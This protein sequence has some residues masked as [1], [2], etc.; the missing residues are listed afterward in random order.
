[1]TGQTSTSSP[2][3]TT[4]GRPAHERATQRLLAQYRS[5][6]ADQPVRLAKKTSN[7]FRLRNRS[8]TG[9][10]VDDLTGVVEIDS[11][12]GLARV[13]GM[14]TYEHVVDALLPH[15]FMPMVVPQLKT[16]TLGGAVTGLGIESSSFRN[17]LPHESVTEL[18]ILTGNGDLVVATPHNE[19]R[20][21][22][23][24]FPNSYGSLGYAVSLT[25]ELERV[26]P[27]VALRHVRFAGVADATAAI[28]TIMSTRSW[29]DEPVDFLDGVVFGPTEVYL[30]LGTWSNHPVGKVSDYTGQE[31]YY[32]SLQRLRRDTLTVR[33]YLWRW[34]TDWFWCSRAFGVQQPAIRRLWPK[35]YKRSDVYAKLVALDARAGLTSRMASVRRQPQRERVIQDIEVSLERTPE[36]VEWFLAN[37]PIEPIWLCPLQLR[38]P[39]PADTSRPAASP[40]GAADSS[41]VPWPLYPMSPGE[42]Y[43][44]VGFWSTVAIAPGDR[45]GDVNRR[46]EAKVDDL[47]GHKSLY[48]DAYYDRETFEALYGGPAYARIKQKYDPSS[49]LPTLYD[50]A[51]TTR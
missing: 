35:R 36:F 23:R 49:R 33:D 18:E 50:K 17:G 5:A 26:S 20:D 16:I 22:F 24:T 29:A 37:V 47:G 2:T 13:Q 32:R 45:D 21:L 7:L 44:N 42:R 6:P 40:E 51:V 8:T 38:E 19:H 30:T 41:A 10:N 46:I 39:S 15:G 11:A 3:A 31:I 27:Y 14:A 43:L 12:A 28:D 25:I 9:L 4:V 1:M 48:S 34:D